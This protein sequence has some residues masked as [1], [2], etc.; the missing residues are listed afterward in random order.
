MALDGRSA[1]ER[2]SA[3][4][5]SRGMLARVTSDEAWPLGRS[6]PDGSGRWGLPTHLTVP[7]PVV[8]PAQQDEQ[9][10]AARQARMAGAR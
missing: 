1:A 7:F 10:Y 5:A 6:R 4:G 2:L 9:R 3:R 8:A